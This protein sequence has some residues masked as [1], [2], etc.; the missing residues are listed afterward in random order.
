MCEWM[1]REKEHK[2]EISRRLERAIS[3]GLWLLSAF[4]CRWR[5]R[6]SARGWPSKPLGRKTAK[7]LDFLFPYPAPCTFPG[8]DLPRSGKRHPTSGRPDMWE[9]HTGSPREPNARPLPGL[10]AFGCSAVLRPAHAC[11]RG[12][13]LRSSP[14]GRSM[15]SSPGGGVVSKWSPVGR[16]TLLVCSFILAAALGQMNFTGWVAAP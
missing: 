13:P 5:I 3:L 14:G 8:E 1:G 7:G 15:Q 10:P 9:S 6:Y 2:E 4:L 16:R 11:V 12:K